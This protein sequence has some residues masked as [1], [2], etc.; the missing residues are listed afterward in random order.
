MSRSQRLWD[1]FLKQNKKGHSDCQVV[2]I[3]NALSYLTGKPP[4]AQ[5]S[6]RYEHLIDMA[7]ARFGA[8]LKIND[9]M[10]YLGLEVKDSFSILHAAIPKGKRKIPLPIETGVWHKSYGN[11]CILIVDYEPITNSLRILNLDKATN[12]HGW[13]YYEDFQHLMYARTLQR[14]AKHKRY[15]LLGLKKE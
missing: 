15:R 5:D 14:D 9:V 10:D 3:V 8:A 13:I 2:A 4:D 11:H 1:G 7:K 6:P 12:N